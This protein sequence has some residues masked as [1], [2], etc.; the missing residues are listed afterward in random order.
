MKKLLILCSVFL[1]V[2]GVAGAVSAVTITYDYSHMWDDTLT[3][4]YSW[5]TVETFDP[6]ASWTWTGDGMILSGSSSGQYA[7][8]YNSSIMSAEDQFNYVTVPDP[9]VGSTGSY[10]AT[11]LGGVYNY[12][13]I[14]WGSVDTYNTLTFYLG[15]VEG[16]S[17]TGSD[18]IQPSDANGNQTAPSTNLYV[19][20]LGLPDFDS[21]TM[22]STQFAFEADNIAVGRVPEPATML[23]LGTGLIGLAGLGRR[24]FLKK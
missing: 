4:P 5:A 8:P 22:S 16:L 24:K 23:L 18:A 15:S 20:F 2:F 10:K 14:F 17:F 7:A 19:N 21:F 3:T 6:S 9:A 11:D 1:L 13:G 12:F